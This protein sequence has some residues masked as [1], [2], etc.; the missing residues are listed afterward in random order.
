MRKKISEL[1]MLSLEEEFMLKEQFNNTFADYPRD[2]CVHQ[3]FEEQVLKTP[4]RTAV[5][6]CDKILTYDELNKLSNRIANGLI[7]KGIKPNDIVAFSMSR[8]SLMIATMLGI[9][10]SGAAYM[11]LD[12]NYPQDRI[13]FMVK[14]SNSKLLI[15]D[16][17]I[18]KYISFK[19]TTPIF[20]ISIDDNFCILHTSGSTGT[21]KCAAIKHK[22]MVNFIYSNQ[23]L[24]NNIDNIIAIN[25]I[26]FDVFEMDTIFAIVSGKPCILA[27]EEQQF[28]QNEFEK[29]MKQYKNCLFWATP[30]KMLNYINNSQNKEFVKNIN[31]YVVGGE[32]VTDDLIDRVLEFNKN[33]DIYTVYGPTETLIYSTLTE[34]RLH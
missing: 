18:E 32:I 27:S 24:L 11:P 23:F 12:P 9:L 1:N 19:E 29:M 10:K 16:K 22:N 34:I 17:N 31:C 33:I 7:T 20:N 2:K 28:V 21:P 15:T 4:D 3:L 26:T 14:D 25:I 13:D 6:A 5:I 30:T 8:N